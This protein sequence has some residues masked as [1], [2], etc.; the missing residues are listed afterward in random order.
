MR[1]DY[2]SE[3]VVFAR[4]QLFTQVYFHKT[5]RAYDYHLSEALKSFLVDRYG[6]SALPLPDKTNEFLKLDDVLL[7]E[8]IKHNQ[9]ENCQ[10]I[11]SRNH[12]RLIDSSS[13]M[14]TPEEEQRINDKIEHINKM[15]KWFHRDIA[16]K[17]WY[18]LND[19]GQENQE[20]VIIKNGYGEPLSRFSRMAKCIDKIKQICLYVKPEDRDILKGVGK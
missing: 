8:F 20:I 6:S 19:N 1:M 14:P 13:E 16:D 5:R 2:V 9:E 10:A 4:Y 7:C 3:S 17:T 15:G 11:L 12:I 18:K